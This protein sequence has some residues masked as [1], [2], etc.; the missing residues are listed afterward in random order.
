MARLLKLD[1]GGEQSPEEA[2]IEWETIPAVTPDPGWERFKFDPQWE[3]D[4]WVWRVDA[5]EKR[6][7]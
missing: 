2:L 5:P 3:T 4:R 1:R 7:V 6:D